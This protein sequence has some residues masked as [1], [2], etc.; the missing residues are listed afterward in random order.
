MTAPKLAAAVALLRQPIQDRDREFCMS[1]HGLM[2]VDE[3]GGAV[4]ESFDD[5]TACHYFLK[6]LHERRRAFYAHT[7]RAGFKLVKGEQSC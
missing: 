6:W 1:Y 4:V 3:N 5:A 7:N 2:L